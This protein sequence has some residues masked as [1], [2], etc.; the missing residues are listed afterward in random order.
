MIDFNSLNNHAGNMLFTKANFKIIDCQICRFVHAVPTSGMSVTDL[1]SSHFYEIE[2]PDYIKSNVD[3]AEWWDLTYGIRLDCADKLGKETILNWLDIGTGPGN[4]LDTAVKRGKRVVGVEPSLEA[5]RHASSK[6]HHVLN[7]YFER[8]LASQIGKFEAIHCSE[9]LEHIPNPIEFLEAIKHSMSSQ[10]IL[11]TVVPNDFSLIQE[12]YTT[13]NDSIDKWWIDPPFHLNYFSRDSLRN[14]L[15]SNGLKVIHETS[16]FPIDLFLLMGDHYV[17]NEALGKE[18][19]SRRKQMEIA[20]LKSGHIEVLN[21]LYE[22]MT[23]L[24][25]GRELVFYSRL[26]N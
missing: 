2:K 9:V 21:K 23:K 8:E 25:L 3:D 7:V 24:G 5:S 10:T 1:Y 26:A 13:L 11:C 4:F 17:G 20:F 6:G 22:D 19:H 15:E 16:M 18:S 12:I 14:L